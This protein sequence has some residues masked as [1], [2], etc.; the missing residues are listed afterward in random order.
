MWHQPPQKAEQQNF[1]TWRLGRDLSR[2]GRKFS[3]KHFILTWLLS[4]LLFFSKVTSFC[5]KHQL[6][7]KPTKQ[8]SPLSLLI[9]IILTLGKCHRMCL[10]KILVQRTQVL[11]SLQ[12]AGFPPAVLTPGRAPKKRGIMGRSASTTGETTSE[13]GPGGKWGQA[14]WCS[15]STGSKP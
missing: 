5:T 14:P 1:Q 2:A 4:N 7:N 12:G 3:I 13:Q 8:E 10:S 9:W 6:L 11:L 15:S